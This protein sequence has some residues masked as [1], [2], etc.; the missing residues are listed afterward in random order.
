MDL[1]FRE[2]ASPFVLL[3]VLIPQGRL[4]DFL[5]NLEEVKQEKELWEFYIHKLPPWDGRT[6]EKFKQDLNIREKCSTVIKPSKEQLETTV[7]LSYA[8]LSSFTLTKKK[9]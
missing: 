2:Y 1:L 5:D 3:D 8:L 4:C 6:F 7:K 9:G